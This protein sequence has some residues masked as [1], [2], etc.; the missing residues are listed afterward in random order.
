M[1]VRAILSVSFV[2]ALLV[3]GCESDRTSALTPVAT[4]ESQWAVLIYSNGNYDGDVLSEQIEGT[5]SR[6]VSTM[7]TIENT[8]A[9]STIETFICLSSAETNGEASIYQIK[10]QSGALTGTGEP[11][12][13]SN[14]GNAD[15]SQ[16]ATLASFLE[17]ALSRSE[18][19]K[20]ALCLSG[21]GAGWVGML[22]DTQH[23]EGMG[24]IDLSATL[25][26]AAARLPL[27]RFDLLSLYA[28]EM[29]SIET[30]VELRHSSLY[31]ASSPW[32][33]EQPHN[34][35]IEKWYRDLA[36]QPTLEAADF[37]AYVVD[38]ER[39]A[40]DTTEVDFFCNLWECG[41]L[42]EV[43]AA[44]DRFVTA[45]CDAAPH[46]SGTLSSLRSSARDEH[47]GETVIDIARYASE[48]AEFSGFADSSFAQLTSAATELESAIHS[49]N[50]ARFGS[51]LSRQFGGMNL[52]LPLGSEVGPLDAA[53]YQ[54]LQICD[55]SPRWATV[56]D[57]LANRGSST[58]TI[59]G[60][61]FW[62][63][64][65]FYNVYFYVD[66]L[67]GGAFGIYTYAE[68]EWSFQHDA[69]DTISFS[70]EFDLQSA[71]SMEIEF[72][73]FIDRDDN[74]QFNT[75]DSLGGWRTG[76]GNFTSFWVHRGTEDD[77]RDV[78]VRLRRP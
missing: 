77:T 54:A 25:N 5:F 57:S 13:I 68:P 56:I 37:G 7:R 12:L 64:K 71:D 55:V 38:A 69:H 34:L 66:T 46:N 4:Q 45:W 3:S 52:Y 18:A 78:T 11:V 42:N 2:I 73:L 27:G 15:M 16:P 40:Q 30:I 60:Q 50:A 32:I 59:S 33:G 61:G 29:S 6:A 10:A 47:Y 28:P 35:A 72:G 75:G 62:P 23:P 43:E 51:T 74:G 36:V 21:S 65:E 49:A 19:Q 63:G 24:L 31:I 58:V 26:N 41:K 48:I 8:V 67:L 20:Y 9:P 76:S 22:G 70:A 53:N 39:L 17:A 1:I 14:L 44:F